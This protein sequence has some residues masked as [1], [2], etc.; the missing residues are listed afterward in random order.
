MAYRPEDVANCFLNAKNPNAAI[1][2][3]LKREVQKGDPSVKVVKD[4]KSILTSAEG[5]R[6]ERLH[7]FFERHMEKYEKHFMSVAGY[8]HAEV[9]NPI[10]DEVIEEFAEAFNETF[11][12]AD[13]GIVV[14]DRKKFESIAKKAVEKISTELKKSDSD[15][16]FLQ[17]VV[18]VSIFEQPV[19]DELK[20]IFP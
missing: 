20:G 1:K 2:N 10:A 19:L 4:L 5:V 6:Q 13:S 12:E 14:K 3:F 7:A 18:V 8:A 16:V 15:S 11:E 9:V 17:G